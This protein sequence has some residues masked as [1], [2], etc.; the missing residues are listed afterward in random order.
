MP[1]AGDELWNP[2][3]GLRTV[4]R[5]TAHETEGELLQ[6]DWIGPAGWTTGPDHVHPFQEER[7]EVLSGRAGLRVDGETGSY[8]PGEVVVAPAGAPHA[9]WTEGAEPL[10]LLVDFRPALRTEVAFETL[11]G[12]AQAGKTNSRG[13]PSNPLQLALTLRHFADEIRLARPPL[14][15]QRALLGPLA[16]AA[17]LLG[18]RAE[19]PYR[20]AG[21]RGLGLA[22][23]LG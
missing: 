3:T 23:G 7:Y 11:A 2:A 21:S 10:H 17:R 22:E 5:E 14:L 6:V 9:V 1:K 16:A 12:L 15:I 19:H 13:A 20:P 18:M 4:F 8:G